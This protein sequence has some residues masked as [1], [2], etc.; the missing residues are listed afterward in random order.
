MERDL[1]IEFLNRIGQIIYDKKGSNILALDVRGVST[2]TDY[3]VIAEGDVDKHVIGIAKAILSGLEEY[4]ETP[5][6]IEGLTEGGWVVL[7]FLDFMIHLFVPPLREKY[8]L[9][10][11]W[12]ESEIL[13]LSLHTG[14]LVA[15]SNKP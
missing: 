7:D 4:G 1:K 14:S 12:R 11:L 3:V 2:I 15:I 13:D 9:E 5:H 6:H 8:Q 10:E